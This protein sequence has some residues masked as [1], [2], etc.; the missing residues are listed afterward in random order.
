MT[1]NTQYKCYVN[2]CNYNINT[3]LTFCPFFVLSHICPVYSLRFM[4]YIARQAPRSMWFSLHKYCSG[5]PFPSPGD[6]PDPGIKPGSPALEAASLPSEPPNSWQQVES[7]SFAFWNFLGSSL[8][9]LKAGWIFS[10]LNLQV[11]NLEIQ[12][13]QLYFSRFPK[14]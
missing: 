7:S 5:M 3:M 14:C 1:S 4:D 2:C 13:G 11:W 8:L 12:K 6:L 10:W 9:Q